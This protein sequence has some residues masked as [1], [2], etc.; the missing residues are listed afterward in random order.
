[1]GGTLARAA[2]Q[3]NLAIDRAAWLFLGLSVQVKL[4]G[5]QRS[6]NSNLASESLLSAQLHGSCQL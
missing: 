1:M 4:N 6:S 5:Q 3:M 2:S